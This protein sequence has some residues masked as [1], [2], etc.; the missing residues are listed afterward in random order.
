MEPT[1]SHSSPEEH[2]AS[3]TASVWHRYE[4]I[5]RR[6]GPSRWGIYRDTEHP[7]LFLE[8]FIVPSWAEHLR[9]H[10][11]ITHAESFAGRTNQQLH[12]KRA[13]SKTSHLRRAEG[14]EGAP[15]LERGTRDSYRIGV[16][17]CTSK[18]RNS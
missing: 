1:P 18:N 11:R 12:I 10:E 17:L 14:L 8:S 15:S 3:A 7:D 5:R 4:R 9:Q 2:R 16:S 6:D 13:K